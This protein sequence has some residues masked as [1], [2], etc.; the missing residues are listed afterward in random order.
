MKCE[1]CEF[2]MGENFETCFSCGEY[3]KTGKED[4]K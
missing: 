4:L 2:D 1:I 3:V